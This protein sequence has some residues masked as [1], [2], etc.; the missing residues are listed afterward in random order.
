M[1]QNK[2]YN[3]SFPLTTNT[4]TNIINPGT[5]TGGTPALTANLRILIRHIRI[6]NTNSVAINVA[7]WKGLT[8]ANTVGTEYG[9]GGTATAGALD[10][11]KG[12]TVPANSSVDYYPGG[13]GMIFETTDFLVGGASAA[14]CTL[15][16]EGEIGLA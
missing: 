13:Q 1:A 4:A 16:A 15:D 8:V 3:R 7:L 5:T 9:F 2:T 10:A 12:T 6:T 14:G 11:N